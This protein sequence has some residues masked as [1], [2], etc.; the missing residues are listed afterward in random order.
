MIYR[1]VRKRTD[2]LLAAANLAILRFEWRGN[3]THWRPYVETLALAVWFLDQRYPGLAD[4]MRS[5]DTTPPSAIRGFAEATAQLETFGFPQPDAVLVLD[6]I[7]DMTVDSASS[8]RRMVRMGRALL[9][10]GHD[11]PEGAPSLAPQ[12]QA[13][14]KALSGDPE[15]WWRRKPALLLDGAELLL[16]RTAQAQDGRVN[17]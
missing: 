7:M 10:A 8:W 1:H 15:E 17:T 4:A 13:M 3:S 2:L 16:E 6:S 9:Q 14:T 5:L 12:I 11:G